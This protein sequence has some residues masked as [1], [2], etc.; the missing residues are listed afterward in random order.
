LLSPFR[1][2]R[3]KSVKKASRACRSR[4]RIVETKSC[5]Q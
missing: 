5:E 1:L 3:G 4:C 2:P